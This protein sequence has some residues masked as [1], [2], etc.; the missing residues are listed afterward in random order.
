MNNDKKKKN[1]L[2]VCVC[3]SVILLYYL[4]PVSGP[5]AVTYTYCHVPVL[6][7]VSVYEFVL[8]VFV[9]GGMGSKNLVGHTHTLM[10]QWLWSLCVRWDGVCARV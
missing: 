8:R 10:C 2:V 6:V 4:K 5:K 7:I 3:L 1:I 9:K